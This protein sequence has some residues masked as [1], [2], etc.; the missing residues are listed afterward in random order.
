[1]RTI[2]TSLAIKDDNTVKLVFK[3]PGGTLPILDMYISHISQVATR[4]R[5]DINE[6][7]M[8]ITQLMAVRAVMRGG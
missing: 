8:L 1:M 7:D 5:L 3:N 4:I 2:E 6:V